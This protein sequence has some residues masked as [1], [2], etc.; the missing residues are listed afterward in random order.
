MGGMTDKLTFYLIQINSFLSKSLES[1][2]YLKIV[3]I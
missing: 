1:D 2:S 3:D